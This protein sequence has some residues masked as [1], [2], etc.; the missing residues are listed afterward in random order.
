MFEIV[1]IRTE[2]AVCPLGLDEK[3]PRFSWEMKA[4]GQNVT[5]VSYRVTVK[6]G[7]KSVWDSGEVASSQNSLV[8]YAGEALAP[9]TRYEVTVAVKNNRGEG[10]EASTYFETGLM[11]APAGEFISHREET[12]PRFF[13][14]FTLAKRPVRARVYATALG[15]YE[16]TLNGKRVGD[17][18]DAPGWTSYTHT[19]QYQTYDVT[20]LLEGEN[21]L[22]ALVGRGWYA[23]YVGYFHQEHCYGDR[24]A[25]CLDLYLD[26]ADGTTQ[27]ISTGSDWGVTSSEL[28]DSEFLKGERC[29][30]TRPAGEVH[31]VEVVPFDKSVIV[32]QMD[33]PVRVT[34][35]LPAKVFITTPKG[36]RVIDFGQNMTGIVEFDYE[37][38]KGQEVSVDHAEILDPEGNFYTANLRWATALDCYVLDG[39]RRTRRPRFTSHGFRYIKL[40]G[41][42]EVSLSDFRALV[43]HSDLEKTAS[44]TCENAL[45]DR[46]QQNFVWGQRGNFFD[47]PT[48]C[49]QRD[50]R[51][52][53][54][55]DAQVFTRTA[56][57]HYNCE[58][59]YRKW[60]Q[61]LRN[62][63]TPESGV[64]VT[65]PNVIPGNEKG[66]AVW[67]DA[68][69]I[70][71]W[72]L[73]T[74]YADKRILAEQYPSMKGWVDYITS[75]SENHL[76]Q[77]DFQFGDWLALDR[78]EVKDNV[79]AT[80]VYFIASAY[81]AYS[82]E[83]VSKA[84]KV[85]G[86]E[87][88][89]ADYQQLHDDIITAFR[90]EYVT[91]T[92]RLVTE[93]QTSYVLALALG[94]VPD[95]FRAREL[96]GLVNNLHK[97]NDHLTTG[98]VGTPHLL[99]VLSENGRHDLAAKLFMN[100][101]FPSW[102]YAV[103][104]GAT[105]VWE[106]WNGI[107]EDGSFYPPDMSSFNHY[108]YGSA[109]DWLYRR[110]VGINTV[111]A[112]Y[113]NLLLRPRPVKEIGNFT[114]SYLTPCG[115][116]SVAVTY[117]N[118]KARFGIEIPVNATAVIDLPNG[119]RYEVGSGSYSY[120]MPE[121]TACV[122]VSDPLDKVLVGE[123]F[124]DEEMSAAIKAVMAADDYAMAWA[125]GSDQTLKT[126]AL[127]YPALEE[128]LRSYCKKKGV[129]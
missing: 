58:R 3:K 13:K 103:K 113:K 127:K 18:Y 16:L 23:G 115:S 128:K 71:P 34:E 50:E 30:E 59:F 90:K 120:E 112:G 10:A 109:G 11:A 86:Y 24:A 102:L 68:A 96:E 56:A 62:E 124:K 7:E 94:L 47:I 91:E 25:L 53:W 81:Y 15:V 76:W 123:L 1:R 51:L 100:D 74:V 22:S 111:R 20:A 41:F 19:L 49:P 66:A 72:T 55:A 38:E 95:R 78:G 37:G 121:E 39:T 54:T 83:L 89:A 107:R 116:V 6:A 17:A 40:T 43:L 104:K 63:Q 92:G 118:G 9:R 42:G 27:V 2:Y 12:V 61:D 46:L 114:C 45:V 4:D 28:L 5:Q 77:K 84:A 60:L 52:G 97:Y 33:E 129:N 87:K 88:D 32:A 122:R 105:T 8:E 75:R 70:M 98:F 82:A 80:D 29:D 99:H 57:F 85:L 48:D 73:Y 119:E 101:D 93:T 35:V 106:R 26:Y 125:Y 69:T 126:L 110:V 108:A 65:V 14:K 21:E 44:F 31:A 79:G 36:E 117:E 67:G 64:P